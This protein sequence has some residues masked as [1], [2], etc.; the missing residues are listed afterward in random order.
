MRNQAH[1]RARTDDRGLVAIE[2]VLIFPVLLA[3]FVGIGSFGAYFNKKIDVTSASRDGARSLALRQT[4]VTYPTG[5]TP[6][7]VVTCAAGDNTSNA[8]VTLTA[9]YVFSIPFLLNET[10]SVTATGTMR[11]GG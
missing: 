3:L 6:S 10:R 8:S 2:F 1:K 7:A 4:V 11:C 9:S 5:M